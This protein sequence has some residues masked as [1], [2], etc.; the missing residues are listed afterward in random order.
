MFKKTFPWTFNPSFCKGPSWDFILWSRHLHQCHSMQSVEIFP[1][2]CHEATCTFTC[3]RLNLFSVAHDHVIQIAESKL[4]SRKLLSM[5]K[6][7]L[8]GSK[9]CL[10]NLL[11]HYLVHW[12][13]QWFP[14]LSLQVSSLFPSKNNVKSSVSGKSWIWMY[15]LRIPYAFHF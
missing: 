15:L 3:T 12:G 8:V 13:W 4:H 1:V 6:V 5:S 2:F 10:F 9:S 14:N 11:R 7:V